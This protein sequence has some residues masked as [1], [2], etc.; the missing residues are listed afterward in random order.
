MSNATLLAKYD[1]PGPRYTSYPTVP[2]WE[3][4][5][6]Q[7]EWVD[8]IRRSLA[9]AEAATRGAAIYIHVPFCESLCTYCGC[10]TRIT[11]KH[12][13]APPY[14]AAVLAEWE[15]LLRALG[16]DRDHSIPLSE[17]HLGGGT[18]TFL[19]S[20]ELRDL[21]EGMLRRCHLTPDAELSLE[22]DPRVTRREQLETLYQLGFRRLSLGVQDFD[23]RVQYII[24]RSQSVE[25]VERVTE[26]ARALGYSGISYDLVYGLPLQTLEGLEE[27]L[28]TVIRLA[29]DRIAFYGYAHVPWVKKGQRRFTEADLPPTPVR[30]AL[31]QLGRTRLEAAGYRDI[32]MDHFARPEDP[33]SL[34]FDSGALHRNFMGYTSRRVEPLIGL[35]VSAIGDAWTAF[36]QNEKSIERYHERVAAG[37]LPIFRG[38][39]LDDEDVALRRNILDLMTRWS[40]SW[41]PGSIPFLDDVAERLSE[42]EQD[43]LVATEASSCR[44]T[45]AGRPFVR[46]IC[47]AFDARLVRRAP[48]GQTFSRTL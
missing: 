35:G 13:V 9:R 46:N 32:G 19:S 36:A 39:L 4:N 17:L 14:V 41:P 34:A 29:P 48:E 2:Y 21:V 1:V 40:T 18:P 23:A 31:Y 8:H 45:E 28:A 42:L 25:Q 6:T 7:D 15:L 27:T 11:K 10:T 24:H 5:P 22:A 26:D 37:E 47:M 38:H 30:Q 33:L 43:G 44:V 12:S 20:G 16:R 3:R